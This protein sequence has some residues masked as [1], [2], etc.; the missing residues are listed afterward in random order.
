MGEGLIGDINQRE[1]EIGK[2]GNVITSRLVG[3]RAYYRRNAAEGGKIG[4]NGKM[5]KQVVSSIYG[6]W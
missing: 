4:R 5:V 2:S 6:V 3:R 1:R